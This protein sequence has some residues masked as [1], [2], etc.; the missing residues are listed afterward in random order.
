MAFI[1]IDPGLGILVD[2]RQDEWKDKLWSC[3]ASSQFVR[4]RL[5]ARARQ[6]PLADLLSL[7]LPIRRWLARN[8]GESAQVQRGNPL[9]VP[10]GAYEELGHRRRC[11]FRPSVSVRRQYRPVADHAT[12]V[13]ATIFSRF[14]EIVRGRH[15]LVCP[16]GSNHH[17]A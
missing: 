7:E 14:H 8:R 1:S 9:G 16:C 3:C 10:G 17:H 2:D 15:Q 6:S 13:H 11:W 4:M 12:R 5:T